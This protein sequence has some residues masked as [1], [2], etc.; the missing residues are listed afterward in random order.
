M[1]NT[2]IIFLDKYYEYGGNTEG[3][4]RGLTIIGCKSARLAD[5]VAVYTLAETKNLFQQKIYHGIYRDDG[6]MVFNGPGTKGD[7]DTWLRL[8]QEKVDKV[9][10]CDCL[11]FTAEV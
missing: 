8:F 2:L 5:L 7:I 4:K 11:Q 3:D 1:S 9:A 10:K 6:F